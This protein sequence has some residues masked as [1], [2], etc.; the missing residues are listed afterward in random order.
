M[1]FNSL[2]FLMFFVAILAVH[3]SGVSWKLK[4]SNLLLGSYIFYAAWN[5]PFVLLLFLSTFVDW[6]IAAKIHHAKTQ[7]KRKHWLW[8]SL[9]FNLGFV[10]SNSSH[11][12]SKAIAWVPFAASVAQS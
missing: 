10:L 2:T 8:L 1:L 3:Y 12:V 6:N 4:K 5:P 9:L 7:K 11:S